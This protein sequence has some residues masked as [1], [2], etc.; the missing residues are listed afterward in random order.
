MPRV[1]RGMTIEA[2]KMLRQLG[3]ERA[4]GDQSR[5][6]GRLAGT[7]NNAPPWVIG[8]HDESEPRS[9]MAERSRILRGHTEQQQSAGR[10]EPYGVYAV[11]AGNVGKRSKRVGVSMSKGQA[12]TKRHGFVPQPMAADRFCRCAPWRH[13]RRLQMIR[14]ERPQVLDANSANN[15]SCARLRASRCNRA[16]QGEDRIG[17]RR[18][19]DG[20]E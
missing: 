12:H 3:C 13:R 6:A 1:K 9:L 18:K 17:C 11:A 2:L 19:R 10:R 7:G 4:G 15:I 5:G 16:E 20:P 14:D 8:V